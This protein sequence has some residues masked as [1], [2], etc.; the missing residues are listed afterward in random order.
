MTNSHV[1][2]S[3]AA[4]AQQSVIDHREIVHLA[5]KVTSLADQLAV[6]T[7]QRDEAIAGREADLRVYLAGAER[8]GQTIERLCGDVDALRP[9]LAVLVDRQAQWADTEA[10]VT[11]VNNWLEGYQP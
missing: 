5:T 8:A 11:F 3:S 4:S 2:P 10:A 9:H 1:H 6:R 7:S